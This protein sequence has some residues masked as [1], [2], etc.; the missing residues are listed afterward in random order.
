M[1]FTALLI[2]LEIDNILGAIL[3]TKVDQFDVGFSYDA[4]TVEYEF[5]RAADFFIERNKKFWLQKKIEDTIVGLILLGIYL[6]F[7]FAPWAMFLLYIIIP[8][9]VN[10]STCK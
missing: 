6:V 4:E 10:A 1:N 9:D 2:L 8:V 3:Q 5:N 7:I